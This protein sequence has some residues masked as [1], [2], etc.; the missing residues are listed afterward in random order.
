MSILMDKSRRRE[1][2]ETIHKSDIFNQ[3]KIPD[4]QKVSISI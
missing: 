2:I 4:E 3:V 1:V